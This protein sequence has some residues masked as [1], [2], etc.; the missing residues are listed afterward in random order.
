[1]SD[2]QVH[3]PWGGSDGQTM[4]KGFKGL[5]LY[6]WTWQCGFRKIFLVA[7]CISFTIYKTRLASSSCLKLRWNIQKNNFVKDIPLFQ[8]STSG[9]HM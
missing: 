2:N 6:F 1:M 8:E 7:L 3:K 9:P 4:A 5:R